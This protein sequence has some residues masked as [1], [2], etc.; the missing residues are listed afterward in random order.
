MGNRGGKRALAVAACT[1]LVL[2][3]ACNRRPTTPDP[4]TPDPTT[5]T[6]VA[7]GGDDHGGGMDHGGDHGM[8]GAGAPYISPDD[9]RLTPEQQARAKDLIA[10]TQAGM[11]RFATV[12]A[13]EAAGYKS[14]RDSDSGF[15]H[16]VNWSLLE[17]GRELDADH[18]E[19]IVFETK[20]GEAKRPV[21]AMYILGNGKSMTQVPEVA[22]PLTVWH[23][24]ED[25]C[26]DPTGTYIQ[27]VYRLDPPRCI[28][29]GTLK[30][31]NPMLHVWTTPQRCGP[32]AEVDDR[33]GLVD[34]YLRSIGAEPPADPNPG[35]VHVHGGAHS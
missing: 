22:G 35:C 24:H 6:T 23:N 16:F 5:T 18:I 32:F 29:A 11:A 20:P 4:V 14:I 12:A 7:T 10:R 21:A 28:P 31:M 33:N 27:G 1:V 25:L 13:V 26:W 3:A 2:S 30:P 9:A 8:P 17:D 15:E 34:K 19:S